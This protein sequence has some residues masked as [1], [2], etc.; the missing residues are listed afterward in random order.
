MFHAKSFPAIFDRFH[1]F[2]SYGFY[3]RKTECLLVFSRNW[4]GF[5]AEFPKL[6][7]TEFSM[8]PFG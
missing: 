8:F 6:L 5:R 2:Q 4:Q 7:N 3:T 1:V